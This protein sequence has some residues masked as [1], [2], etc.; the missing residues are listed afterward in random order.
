MASV[1]ISWILVM[2]ACWLT[3]RYVGPLTPPPAENQEISER[4]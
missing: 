1:G 4:E 3:E 2:L